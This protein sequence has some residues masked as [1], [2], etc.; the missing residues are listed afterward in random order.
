[1]MFARLA[2]LLALVPAL[3]T[4]S[5]VPGGYFLIET[6]GVSNKTTSIP[7]GVCLQ[8]DPTSNNGYVFSHVTKTDLAY[9]VHATQYSTPNCTDVGIANGLPDLET[10]TYCRSPLASIGIGVSAEPPALAPGL[11]KLT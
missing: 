8:F 7:L 11:T 5:L 10:L 2:G 3:S 9:V 4:S 6:C 1:M